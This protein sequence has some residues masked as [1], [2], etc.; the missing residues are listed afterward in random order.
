MSDPVLGPLIST[1]QVEQAALSVLREWFSAYLAAAEREAGLPVGTVKRPPG[2]EFYYGGLDFQSEVPGALP[3]VIVVVKPEGKPEPSANFYTQAYSLKVAC[4]VEAD[5]EEEARRNA[6]LMGVAASL[7]SH[8]GGLRGLAENTVLAMA[9]DPEF[10]SP[11]LSQRRLQ[12]SVVEFTTWI[13]NLINRAG[14]AAETI[15]GSPEVV[16]PELPPTPRPTVQTTDIIVKG[17]KL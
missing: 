13:P 15:K 2:E 7:F 11:E 1:W 8:L 16:V 10:V 12:R 4:I 9:P 6:S 5:T 17:E 3:V 14:P